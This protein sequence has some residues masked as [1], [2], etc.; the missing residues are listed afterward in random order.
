M[1][2]LVGRSGLPENTAEQVFDA[3]IKSM[4]GALAPGERIEFRGFGVFTVVPRKSGIG[5]NR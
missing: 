3:L 1:N 2:S 5:R 4:K